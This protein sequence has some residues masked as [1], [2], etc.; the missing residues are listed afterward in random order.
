MD[1]W[2]WICEVFGD[3]SFTLD[4]FRAE[5]PGPNP[6]KVVR[7][8][9]K[10]KLISRVQTGIYKPISLLDF[11][12]VMVKQ[13]MSKEKILPSAPA[14][15]AYS[16]DDA[17]RIWTD[18]YYWTGF[19]AGYKPVTLR[20]ET[21]TGNVGRIS[22]GETMHPALSKPIARRCLDWFSFFTLFARSDLRQGMES[23]LSRW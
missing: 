16:H 6:A 15:F 12:R 18:G 10:L 11:S 5:F 8:L 20:S 23:G 13:S 17:V 21:L 22:S 7:D 4:Q 3:Q 9:V 19:T 1:L 14:S 2:C